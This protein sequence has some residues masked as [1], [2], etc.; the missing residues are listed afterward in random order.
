M[1]EGERLQKVLA[2]A[3]IG[4]RRS[5]EELIEQGRVRVNG[6]KARLGARVDVTKDKVE[7]DGSV[8][9]VAPDLVYFLLNKPVGVVATADDEEG[10]ETVVELIDTT[11]RIWP[12]GRLDIATEGALILTNDGDLTLRLTHPRF[13]I[14]KAYLAEVKGSVGARAVKNLQRGVE[15]ED[16]VTAPAEVE[17]AERGALRSLVRL[18]ISEGRNRQIRRMLE[19]VG[20]EVVRLVRT[21]IGPLKLGRLKTGTFRR[22]SPEEVHA[23]YRASGSDR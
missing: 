20:H 9:P 13:G 3:G 8:I 11:D 12:V 16:G 22:L 2:R 6:V 1:T 21:A 19:A 17:V 14:T 7:V 15:L 23:L 10:R 18:E 5:N 4:S